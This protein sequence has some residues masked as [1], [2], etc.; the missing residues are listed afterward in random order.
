MSLRTSDVSGAERLPTTSRLLALVAILLAAVATLSDPPRAKAI[1]IGM[2]SADESW[3]QDSGWDA[4]QR[5][6]ATV[7]RAGISQHH[8]SDPVWRARIDRM[9]QQTAAR[10]IVV[11]PY[12]Y[13]LNGSQRFPA[14]PVWTTPGNNWDA[15][16]HSVV[17][18]YGYNGTFWAENPSLPY[19]PVGAWEV[20][21]EPNLPENNPDLPGDS[22]VHPQ[23]YAR[24]LTHSSALIR[25]AQ[26]ARSA[27]P[28]QVLFGGLFSPLLADSLS[29]SDFLSRAKT[30]EAEGVQ[31]GAAFNALSLHPYSFKGGVAKL[32]EHVTSARDALT[33][34]FGGKGL[35]ITELG[36]PVSGG[37]AAVTE[38]QQSD[39]LA[40]SFNWL[41]SVAGS[42][43]IHLV[44][45]YAYRDDP[46]NPSWDAHAGLRRSDGSF[47]P[48][49]HAFQTQ[50][51]APPWTQDAYTW[52]T[53]SLC[54]G[55]QANLDPDLLSQG[56]GHLEVFVT[57]TDSRLWTKN[58]SAG[59]WNNWSVL[60]GAVTSGPGAV[61][62]GGKATVVARVPDSTV[63]SWWR[64][65]AWASYNLGGVNTSGPDLSAWG[66]TR[67][68]MFVRGSDNALWHRP[69]NSGQW[70]AWH[71]LGGTL[72]S[73]PAAVSWGPN[74]IDVVAR[75]SS[76]EVVRWWFDGSWHCCENVGG[77]ATSSPDLASTAPGILNLVVRGSD[78][79]L[80]LRQFDAGTGWRA[81]TPVP[82]SNGTASG[83]GAVSWGAN[84][85]LDI[86][87]LRDDG[88]IKHWWWGP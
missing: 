18:R 33:A 87:A 88:Q 38:Q 11:L 67:M 83:P 29:V 21:N 44:V 22:D 35:W 81:W 50:T 31:V 39:Y 77:S 32:Q 56:P 42:K 71:S 53:E 78:H 19:H 2:M 5:S 47:R 85:R 36:W 7:F 41:R 64:D 54:G 45:W 55:G 23:H 76:N 8:Y 61:W 12:L 80:W 30:V 43:G 62:G 84:Y 9:F 40:G 34:T 63:Q 48:A 65:G 58:F 51:G 86:V 79:R 49:W 46:C 1:Q 20:W 6:G 27:T 16:V 52:H 72:T 25:S 37:D 15:F 4:M 66:T 57:G 74:R 60:S 28:T 70:G 24:F 26:A 13:G 69:W 3:L 10:G 68:D 73:D 75:N 14:P 59:G 17:Q 82:D